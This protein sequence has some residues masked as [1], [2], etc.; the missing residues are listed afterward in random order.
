MKL[1]IEIIKSEIAQRELAQTIPNHL[2]FDEVELELKSLRKVLKL[3]DGVKVIVIGAGDS[4]EMICDLV[5]SIY[6]NRNVS[7][8][9]CTVDDGEALPRGLTLNKS[10]F[11]EPILF[12]ARPM[13]EF[14]PYADVKRDNHKRP[15]KYHR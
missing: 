5:H 11:D 6:H 8:L 13:V 9:V 7:E 1:A 14:E 2:R 12:K 3:I 10:K 15:Y 4:G